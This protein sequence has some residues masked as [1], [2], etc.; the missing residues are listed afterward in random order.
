M[1]LSS[2]VRPPKGKSPVL[3]VAGAYAAAFR[4]APSLAF[5]LAL[6][7]VGAT[8]ADPLSAAG[9]AYAEGRFLEA[10]ELA[11]AA[12]NADGYVLASE[13][14]E[15][16]GTYVAAKADRRALYER[17]MRLGEQAI[18]LDG[19]NARAHFQAAQA[20]GLYAETLGPLK[21]RGYVGRVREGMEKALELDPGFA[22]AV[23]GLGSWHAGVID[24]AG[25][26]IARIAYGAT[27]KQAIAHFDQALKL[28]P[29]F[30]EAHYEYAKGL[31]AI[32]PRRHRERARELLNRAIA[33][34]A[35][36]AVGRALHEKAVKRLTELDG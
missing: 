15:R 11:E 18:R 20:V 16:H 21:A 26:M 9:L 27:A 8:H 14:V 3:W 13:S 7:A 12:G 1:P 33:L 36:N 10:A 23:L 17:A 30:K 34:P 32:N 35:E 5:A 6:S 19:A 22:E 29:D 31:L 4:V 2:A 25:R 24:G 28:A